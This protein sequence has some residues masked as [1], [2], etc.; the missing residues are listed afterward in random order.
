MGYIQLIY[1]VSLDRTNAPT[2]AFHVLLI[3]DDSRE[4]KLTEYALDELGIDFL[5]K[6]VISLKEAI[7]YVEIARQRKDLPEL[8]G[9]MLESYLNGVPSM[10]AVRLLRANHPTIPVIVLAGLHSQEDHEGFITAGAR[11]IVEKHIDLGSFVISLSA[12]SN[13]IG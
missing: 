4:M 3:G 12:I 6:S 13:L 5:I 10:D 7:S 8:K 1:H 11:S 9:I 2:G